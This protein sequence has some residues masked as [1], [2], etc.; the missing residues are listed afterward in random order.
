MEENR[1]QRQASDNGEP[2]RTYGEESRIYQSGARADA[3]APMGGIEQSSVSRPNYGNQQ[4]YANQPGYGNQPNYGNYANYGA[5]YQNGYGNP[6]QRGAVKDIFCNILLVIMPL[7]VIIGFFLLTA[8]TLDGTMSGNYVRAISS[9]TY[10]ALSMLSNLLF[11]AFI[12][13]VVF[14][15]VNINKANYK[16]TGLILF[17]IFLNPGYYIWRAYVLGRKK[18]LPV[19]YTVLYGILQVVYFCY[20]FY[21][22]FRIAFDMVQSIY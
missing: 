22:S 11:I 2:L 19:V 21:T 4:G 18:T 15:I 20:T 16:I 6:Q 10:T 3:N 5:G 12:V 8:F 9:G 13:F 14:D 1:N 17:A 7:R